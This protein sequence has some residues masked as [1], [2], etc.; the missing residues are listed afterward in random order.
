MCLVA[1]A[2]DQSSRYPFVMAANRDEFFDRPAARLGW[3]EPETGGP[4]ILG[5]RD[6]HAGG[7]W[8]GMTAL[9]RLGMVTNIRDPQDMDPQAPSRG[10]IVP[11]WLKGDLHMSMLWPR[12]AMAGHNGFNMIALDFAQGECFW[13]NNKRVYP[14]RLQRG[15]FGLSNAQLNTP[16]PKVQGLKARLRSSLSEAHDADDL[17]AMLF[18]ALADPQPAPDEQLPRT[19][20]STEWE[21]LLSSAFIRAGNGLYGT[22]CSTVIVTERINKRLVTHVMERTFSA[23]ST[24][25]LM[26][27]VT[28]RNWPPRHTMAASDVAKLDA[29]LPP[30]ALRHDEDFESSVISEHDDA[31]LQA[32]SGAKRQRA[33]SLIKPGPG[34]IVKA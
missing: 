27:R 34:V 31:D 3:W 26:R 8:L 23:Q 20:V 14:E 16:W 13:L 5:G 4:A 25:A 11:Q 32:M 28:L 29:T 1:F 10:Q 33:R 19:G 22:R 17:A 18:E 30:P 7:T 9:G 24:V 21:R 15:I 12:L 2:L 6:L